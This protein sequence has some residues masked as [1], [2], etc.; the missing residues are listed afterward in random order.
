MRSTYYLSVCRS[1]VLGRL[2]WV[3]LFRLSYEAAGRCGTRFQAT[4][5]LP[6]AA[7]SSLKSRRQGASV[8]PYAALSIGCFSVPITWWLAVP[9]AS[10]GRES[11]QEGSHRAFCDL[12]STATCCHLHLILFV[13]NESLS[14]AHIQGQ[15][16]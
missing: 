5:G 8:L 3:G 10:H 13:R 16:N 12:L 11:E 14:A 9:K 6:G 4:E 2:S 15:G 1:G 7:G